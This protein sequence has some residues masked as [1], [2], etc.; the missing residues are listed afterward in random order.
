MD[1]PSLQGKVGLM[2][3]PAWQ[4]GGPRTSTWG[5]TGLAFPKRGKN[6]ELAW[7]LAMHLYFD[8]EQL[9]PRFTQTHILPPLIESWKQPEFHAINEFWGTSLGEAFIPLAPQVP[10]SPTNAYH[11][12]AIAKISKAFAHTSNHYAAHGEVGLRDRA[13]E[14]LKIS[15]NEV[16]AIMRRNRFFVQSDGETAASA[17]AAR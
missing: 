7:K 11:F 14:E 3:L 8:A 6:F 17:E 15:A 2:P 16:R 5:A 13:R 1:V 10:A 4:P 9:G 12:V